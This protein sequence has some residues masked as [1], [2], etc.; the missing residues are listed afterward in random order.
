MRYAIEKQIE[1]VNTGVESSFHLL[2]GYSVTYPNYVHA[3]VSTYV[4]QKAYE[5]GKQAISQTSIQVLGLT[6][7]IEGNIEKAIVDALV[8]A[9]ETES[10][11]WVQ[12]A[13]YLTGGKVIEIE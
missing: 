6:L 10:G 7:P 1:D 11:I 3:T 5:S 13:T 8:V 2:T 9:E 4:S 12:N